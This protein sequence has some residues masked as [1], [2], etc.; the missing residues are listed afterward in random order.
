MP[1]P[2]SDITEIPTSEP[3]EEATIEFDLQNR[4]VQKPLLK[5]LNVL[6]GLHDL[7]GLRVHKAEYVNYSELVEVVGTLLLPHCVFKNLKILLG[8]GARSNFINQNLVQ[9]AEIALDVSKSP[10]TISIG[11]GNEAKSS[12]ETKPII[13]KIRKLFKHTS[14]YTV[15]ELGKYDLILGMP[16]FLHSWCAISFPGELP[17]VK[18]TYKKHQMILQ[19]RTDHS[20]AVKCFHISRKDFEL[21]SESSDEVYKIHYSCWQTDHPEP[22]IA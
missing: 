4:D 22:E 3:S 18:I 10:E 14:I 6:K 7:D 9:N 5:H 17:E 20:S 11:D 12:G 2:R 8:I 13:M 16:F 21:D 1:P 15:M 19:L